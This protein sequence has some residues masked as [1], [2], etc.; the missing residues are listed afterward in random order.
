MSRPSVTWIRC[1]TRRLRHVGVIMD[2]LDGI[3]H[4]AKNADHEPVTAQDSR[5]QNLCGARNAWT[6]HLQVFTFTTHRTKA[7]TTQ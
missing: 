6:K 4:R 7:T 2:F 3:L 5:G 1:D